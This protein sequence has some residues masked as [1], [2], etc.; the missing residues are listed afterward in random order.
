MG[1]KRIYRDVLQQTCGVMGVFC[2]LSLI[3]VGG[4]LYVDYHRYLSSYNITQQSELQAAQ[5]KISLNVDNLKKLSTLTAKRIVASLG[6][7]KRIQH[8]LV[9]S[10]SLL[11]DAEFLKIQ[12][13]SYEKFSYPQSLIT[14]FGVVPLD[15]GK[16]SL[17]APD[18]NNPAI[19]F[20]QDSVH[21]KIGVFN[22]AGHLDGI[23]EI[24]VPPSHFKETLK[25]GPTLSFE[26][27]S[28]NILLQKSPLPL[29]GKEPKPFLEYLAQ[30][31]SH[32]TVFLLFIIFSLIFIALGIYYSR[33]RIKQTFQEEIEYLK[34][35][36]SKAQ[37]DANKENAALLTYQKRIETH[38][39]TCQAYKSFQINFQNH[40]REQLHHILRSLDVVIRSFKNP[41][42]AL[43]ANELIEILG[44]CLLTAEHISSGV[45]SPSKQEPVKVI[46]V[47]GNIRS[48]F[49]EK[50]Y[51]SDLTMELHCPENLIYYGDPLFVEFVLLNLI[52][53][54]LHMVPKNG[55]VGIKVTDQTEGLHVQVK[56]NGFL[57]NDKS[58]KQLQQAF[59]FFMPE[60]LFQQLCRDNG[61]LYEYA[62][63]KDGLNMG[64]I[65]FPKVLEEPLDSN[66]IPLFN[67]N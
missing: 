59:D 41:N 62:K 52:G 15:V 24:H 3:F 63:D 22:Q 17:N 1:L 60:E 35:E 42:A 58:Q 45:L 30:N 47:L 66:V 34:D 6:D 57:V 21:S 32:Y 46:N 48:L 23:L 37:A 40:R 19:S 43:P 54:P 4:Y 67:K 26:L 20:D 12:K 11:P 39:V 25:I 8:I 55:K 28:A 51:K 56:D 36:L 49:T 29:Y 18:G 13:M 53:K 65:L 50:M 64:K 16:K 5:E 9:S 10:H 2:F 61:F 44:S 14:R 38:Q 7:I 33:F 27:G 31:M